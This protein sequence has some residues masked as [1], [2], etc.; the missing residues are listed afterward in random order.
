ML[1]TWP[2]VQQHLIAPVRPAGSPR[3]CS[4]APA[5]SAANDLI[6]SATEDLLWHYDGDDIVVTLTR[7]YLRPNES[8]TLRWEI[9][10]DQATA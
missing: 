9:D 5:S 3:S 8:V 4:P 7:D 10:R 6:N 1:A 2:P